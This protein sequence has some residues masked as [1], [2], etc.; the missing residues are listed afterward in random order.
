[1]EHRP[2]FPWEFFEIPKMAKLWKRWKIHLSFV[3]QKKILFFLLVDVIT[4]YINNKFLKYRSIWKW[5]WPPSKVLKFCKLPIMSEIFYKTCEILW[6]CLVRLIFTFLGYFSP[7]NLD[8][9]FCFVETMLHNQN[10]WLWG[11][12]RSFPNQVNI[13]KL[14]ID[15]YGN[16]TQP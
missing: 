11:W 12:L 8:W 10:W 1:M 16:E 4:I 2:S 7:A 15:M 6:F 3:G 5:S 13:K 14:V 9:L